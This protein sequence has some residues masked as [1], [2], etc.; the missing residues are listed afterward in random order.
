MRISQFVVLSQEPC[1]RSFIRL[2]Y[3]PASVSLVKGLV[4]AVDLADVGARWLEWPRM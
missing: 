2:I 4:G 1:Q 3:S